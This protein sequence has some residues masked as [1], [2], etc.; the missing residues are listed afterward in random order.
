VR[1]GTPILLVA[2]LVVAG[3]CTRTKTLDG[4]S[5]N[6]LLASEMQKQLD[7]QGVTVSCPDDVP[8]EAG[9]VFDCIATT[10]DGTTMTIRVTQTD[11]QGHVTFKVVGAG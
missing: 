3:G 10:P 6:G 11:D 8:A 4:P 9:G 1:R 5:L 2:L 7:V